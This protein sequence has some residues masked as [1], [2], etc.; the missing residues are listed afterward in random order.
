MMSTTWS[1]WH[2]IKRLIQL[3][4]VLSDIDK[5]NELASISGRSAI[6]DE[7]LLYRELTGMFKFIEV[8]LQLERFLQ[9]L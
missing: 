5:K 7:I 1:S 6:T 4:T 2:S 9:I 3:Q 8:R